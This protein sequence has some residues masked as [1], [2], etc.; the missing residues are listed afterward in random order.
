MKLIASVTLVIVTT[1]PRLASAAAI[2]D[3]AAYAGA[4]I[5]AKT[6]SSGFALAHDSYN[7]MGTASDGRIYYV[8]SSENIDQGAKMFRFDPATQSVAELGDLTEACG[9]GGRHAIPQGKSHVSF[10]ESSGKLYFATHVG[11]YSIVD[12]KET[13]G[14][15]PAGYQPYPGGHLL[16]YDLTTG[17]FDD[18]WLVPGREGILALAMDTR[19]GRLFALTWPRG[20]FYRFDLSRK[21]AKSFGPQCAEGE[22]GVGA[23]YRTVC[24]AIAVD[25]DDGS[26]YFTTAEGVINRYRAEADAIEA[27]GGEDMKKDYFGIY[28]PASPGH[29]G[30]NW[31]QVFWRDRDQSVYGMHGNSGYLFR[32]DPRAVRLDVLERLTSEASKRCGMFDQFSYGY[33]GFALGPDQQTIHYLTGGPIFVNGRRLS[34]KASTAMGEAKG[35]EDLHLVTYDLK[36]QRCT[37][38]G[39]VFY[40]DG[41]RPLYVNSI[42]V[43]LDGTVYTLARITKKGVT[44]SDLVAFPGP[45][46]ASPPRTP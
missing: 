27:V 4:K 14:V 37:D 17:R 44:R 13:I 3:G 31:R 15:P 12:G 1:L 33:L 11:V 7:G 40:E 24:R 43:G 16:A 2:A 41:Q 25:L 22:D 5:I 9:E 34:G 46:K 20:I 39:A 19:R 21:E 29:M 32:F 10:V 35:L 42:A 18:L 6:Y 8:L 26:A 23:N 45:L 30:Y 38:H 28:D 36:A